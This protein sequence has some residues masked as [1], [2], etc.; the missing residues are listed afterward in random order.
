MAMSYEEKWLMVSEEREELVQEARKFFEFV[1]STTDIEMRKW[2][3]LEAMLDGEIW[4]MD[5][6]RK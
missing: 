5:D 2:S 1:G 6:E 4:R 3:Y